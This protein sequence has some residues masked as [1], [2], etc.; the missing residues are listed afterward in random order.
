MK[1]VLQSSFLTFHGQHFF[2]QYT[3][4]PTFLGQ[5]K[6]YVYIP[7]AVTEGGCGLKSGSHLCWTIMLDS[8]SGR[9]RMM[10]VVVLPLLNG[11]SRIHSVIVPLA[12]SHGSISTRAKKSP[13]RPLHI[14][15]C[16]DYTTAAPVAFTL[17]LLHIPKYS[18]AYIVVLLVVSLHG[19]KIFMTFL[20]AQ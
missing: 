11:W 20:Q 16:L 1:K 13:S 14:L 6:L 5:K 12:I 7:F 2:F 9:R 19:P 3:T 18:Y 8:C 17:L 15:C 10:M 4:L